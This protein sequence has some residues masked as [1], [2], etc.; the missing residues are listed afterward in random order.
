MDALH[1]DTKFSYFSLK[2]GLNVFQRLETQQKQLLLSI[3]DKYVDGNL[4][5]EYSRKGYYSIPSIYKKELA[6][7][8]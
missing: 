2:M 6:K 4:A 1:F 7:Q 3:D 8:F 5:Q